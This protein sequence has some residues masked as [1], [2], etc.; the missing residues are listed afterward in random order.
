MS[1]TVSVT[2]FRSNAPSRTKKIEIDQDP[3]SLS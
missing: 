2:P 1:S 3:L